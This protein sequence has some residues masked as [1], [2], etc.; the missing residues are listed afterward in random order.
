M[1]KRRKAF[2]DKEKMILQYLE[3]KPIR[4]V[5]WELADVLVQ[6]HFVSPPYTIRAQAK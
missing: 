5:P 1:E 4:K 2:I 6:V 3:M